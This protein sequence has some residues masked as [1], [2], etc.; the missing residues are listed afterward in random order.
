MSFQCHLLVKLTTSVSIL[1]WNLWIPRSKNNSHCIEVGMGTIGHKSFKGN[2][3]VAMHFH[4]LQQRLPHLHL[5]ILGFTLHVA[6]SYC[7][8]LLKLRIVNMNS[9]C[10]PSLHSLYII[11]HHPLILKISPR[12]HPLNNVRPTC[13]PTC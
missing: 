2:V 3:G 6:Y 12:L 9:H 10:G 7:D 11:I 13:Y 4:D 8:H 1:H 5:H